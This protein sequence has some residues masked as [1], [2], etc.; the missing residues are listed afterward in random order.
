[1]KII[2]LINRL[3]W[4]TLMCWSVL[5]APTR[6]AAIEAEQSELP[7]EQKDL[8]DIVRVGG[9]VVVGSNETCKDLVVVLGSVTMDGTAQKDVVV[10]LGNLTINGEAEGDVVNI[11]GTTKVG[12]NAK[13]KG[14]LVTVMG[15][16]SI[17][18]TAQIQGDRVNV[19][20]GAVVPNFD[21]IGDYFHQGIGRARPLA[22]GLGW[23]WILSGIGL[24]F[25][26]LL[27]LVFPRPVATCA[28]V[29]ETRPV[30]SL[31]TG[32]LAFVFAGPLMLLL[33]ISFLGILVIPFILCAMVLLLIFG[34]AA[35]YQL[36]GL[37][38]GRQAK[39]EALQHP[40][41]A[42][43]MGFVIFCLL[44]MIPILGF[45]V[46]GILI[47][48]G[49][50]CALLALFGGLKRE[51]AVEKPTPFPPAPMPPY[52][53]AQEQNAPAPAPAPATSTLNA[54]IEPVIPPLTTTPP[55]ATTPSATSEPGVTPLTPPSSSVAAVPH[56]ISD[57]GIPPLTSPPVPPKAPTSSTVPPFAGPPVAPDVSHLEMAALPRATLLQRAGAIAL[58]FI[59]MAI[60]LEYLHVHHGWLLIWLAYHIAM[61]TWKSTTVG[62]VV[63]GLKVVRQNG[64]PIDVSV[65][66]VRC[67]GAILSTVALGLGFFRIAWADDKL[68]WH[69]QIA[70][71]MVVHVPKGVPLISI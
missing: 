52:H 42:L 9:N 56:V 3:A 8:Q 4:T 23:T 27:A 29:L 18:P 59:L 34:K 32:L 48:L 54:V 26:V 22:P 31:V 7:S 55:T 11:L 50:G 35:I 41:L 61:W 62:G 2:H 65:A 24:L 67:L 51:P 5:I 46:W 6:I 60:I 1:M 21:S 57:Q 49:L 70:G 16:Q 38:I 28:R 68:S 39:V 43:I 14:D 36:T 37:Q 53:D 25:Y 13:I 30:A 69:D 58:D 15:S 44:A 63:M 71:T 33:V 45:L 12:P 20:P 40:L 66:A 19:S 17:H 64:R 47:P 10:V